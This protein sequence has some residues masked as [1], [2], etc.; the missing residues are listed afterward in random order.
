MFH[1]ITY[2]K[3]LVEFIFVQQIKIFGGI[4]PPNNNPPVAFSFSTRFVASRAIKS[5]NISIAREHV[6]SS[7]RIAVWLIIAEGSPSSSNFCVSHA[8]SG[9]FYIA[10]ESV[11]IKYSEYEITVSQL[12]IP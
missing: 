10:Q 4:P 12:T 1:F 11:N 8:G 9:C 7:S 5:T 2:D 6:G 3:I